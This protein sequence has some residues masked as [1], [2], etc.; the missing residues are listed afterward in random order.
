MITSHDCVAFHCSKPA[1]FRVLR[2]AGRE[3]WFCATHYDEF[4]NMYVMMDAYRF[5]MSP[6]KVRKLLDE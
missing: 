6:E 5:G 3:K 2:A 4:M 1:R